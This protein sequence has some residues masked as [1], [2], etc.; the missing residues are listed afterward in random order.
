MNIQQAIERYPDR[1]EKIK[2]LPVAPYDYSEWKDEYIF[3]IQRKVI[4]REELARLYMDSD[5]YGVKSTDGGMDIIF[6][7]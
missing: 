6:N 3:S 4:K 7:K 1:A 5:F 2:L